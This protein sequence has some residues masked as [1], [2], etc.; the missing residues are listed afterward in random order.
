MKTDEDR[1]G[2]MPQ[3]LIPQIYKATVALRIPETEKT[4]DRIRQ[5]N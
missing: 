5:A 3:L 2:K 1:W 4:K